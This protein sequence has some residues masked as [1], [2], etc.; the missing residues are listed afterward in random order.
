MP[1]IAQEA[2]TPLPRQPKGLT[3]HKAP[4]RDAAQAAVTTRTPRVGEAG[5]VKC[6]W[7]TRARPGEA[8]ALGTSAAPQLQRVRAARPAS[9]SASVRSARLPFSQSLTQRLP[10]P[11]PLPEPPPPVAQQPSTHDDLP[12]SSRH[13]SFVGSPSAALRADLARCAPAGQSDGRRVNSLEMHASVRAWESLSVPSPFLKRYSS[14]P[15]ERRPPR[16]RTAKSSPRPQSA[17]GARSNDTPP[18]FLTFTG[19]LGTTN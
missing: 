4:P 15:T 14:P 11:P 7:I 8:D 10:S 3:A 17:R 16:P 19:L 13:P 5:H 9:A 1:P 12:H 2:P 6:V 18:S